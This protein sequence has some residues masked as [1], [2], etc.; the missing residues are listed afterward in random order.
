MSASFVARCPVQPMNQN[1]IT[2]VSEEVAWR[3]NWILPA[4]AASVRPWQWI[5][6]SF[7]LAA[8]VFSGRLWEAQSTLRALLAFLVF[9]G[10]SG[11]VY[12]INDVLDRDGDRRHPQKRHRPIASGMVTLTA[13]LAA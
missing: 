2:A 8:L 13:A 4:L 5:K 7:V 6:N 11:S 1:D 10:L 9:C 12:L 3:K